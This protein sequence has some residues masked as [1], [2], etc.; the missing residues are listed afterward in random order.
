MSRHDCAMGIH[1]GG[2]TFAEEAAILADRLQQLALAATSATAIAATVDVSVDCAAPLPPSG[3][4]V[5]SESRAVSTD[6]IGDE[7]AD[8]EVAARQLPSSETAAEEART[9]EADARRQQDVGAED[10]YAA[11]SLEQAALAEV[12]AEAPRLAAAREAEA[13]AIASAE[14]EARR[15]IAATEEVCARWRADEA[16]EREAEH[17]AAAKLRRELSEAE[18]RRQR[19]EDD[20]EAMLAG[21]VGENADESDALVAEEREL[22]A[23]AEAQGDALEEEQGRLQD[24]LGSLRFQIRDAKRSQN[25]RAQELDTQAQKLEKQRARLE[26]E[27]TARRRTEK[28][29]EEGV[30]GQLR[31]AQELNALLLSQV[32]DAEE[33]RAAHEQT[34]QTLGVSLSELQ[35][36]RAEELQVA[37][38]TQTQTDEVSATEGALR[39]ESRTLQNRATILARQVATLAETELQRN[40]EL[41]EAESALERAREESENARR[42]SEI[43]E[44]KLQVAQ[45]QFQDFVD[46]GTNGSN[47]GIVCRAGSAA[48]GRLRASQ[49]SASASGSS[50]RGDGGCSAQERGVGGSEAECGQ[51]A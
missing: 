42:R 3:M 45:S 14:Q 15:R 27:Q 19:A 22:A 12:V 7:I 37:E 11:Q 38:Q 51:D 33:E 29:S 10:F 20:M 43:L 36:K 44:W 46:G 13:S 30:V 23:E 17:I 31:N 40:L 32:R 50:S 9:E 41:A 8:W 39:R 21:G 16:A 47:A 18:G 5:D 49:G 6:L 34:A 25:Q 4:L 35:G 2:V 28:V 26:A 24:E 48:S 1:F